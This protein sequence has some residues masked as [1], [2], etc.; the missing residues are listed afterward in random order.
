MEMAEIADDYKRLTGPQKAAV[1]MLALEEDQSA[2]LFEL[3]D[4]DE[5]R[6]R[7]ARRQSF[8]NGT[9]PDAEHWQG[10]GRSDFG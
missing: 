1:F 8:D 9:P 4:D 7:F 5:I 2:K 6:N 3:M 10:P